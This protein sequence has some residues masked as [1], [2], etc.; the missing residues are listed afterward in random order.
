MQTIV[1]ELK[2][3]IKKLKKCIDYDTS[4]FNSI[5]EVID[6]VS[7]AWSGSLLGY[8]ANVYYKDFQTPPKGAKF[9]KEW[10]INN[11]ITQFDQY[12]MLG[13]SV[14]EWQEYTNEEVT[15]YINQ[16]VGEVD[17][18]EIIK[19]SNNCKQIFEECKEDIILLI[20]STDLFKKDTFLQKLTKETEDIIIPSQENFLKNHFPKKMTYSTRDPRVDGNISY[21]PHLILESSLYEIIANFTTCD[22]LSKQINKII[23]YLSNKIKIEDNMNQPTKPTNKVF[24]VH[25]HDNALKNEVARFIEKLGLEAIILHEQANKGKTIIEKIEHYSDV[26]FGIVLYTPCDIG[27]KTKENLQPRARQNVVFEHGYLVGKIGRK[28]VIA[29]V[30]DKVEKPSDISGIVYIDIS[31]N[32]KLDLAKEMKELG[33]S[34]DLSKV[35]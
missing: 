13:G 7:K 10:G 16:M 8:Q 28:N 3:T 14:G 30:K 5:F 34:I 26:S 17:I 35:I 20:N 15:N 11:P 33:Y 9:S 6:Q 24:I 22:L 12:N 19:E 21:P 27:G 1:N 2:Q 4:K 18:S 31:D 23:K 25:G 29:L 32:W